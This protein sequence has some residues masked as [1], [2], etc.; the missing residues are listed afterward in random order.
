MELGGLLPLRRAGFISRCTY[1]W[2]QH[3]VA[4][5]YKRPLRE[6]DLYALDD[7]LSAD[8][9]D[10]KMDTAWQQEIKERK[11]PHL[12]HALFVAYRWEFL[13]M[14]IY[15]FVTDTSSVISPIIVLSVIK[16]LVKTSAA[17]AEGTTLPDIG[18][19]IGLT[20]ALLF[21]QLV[22]IF[23]THKARFFYLFIFKI[24]KK[25]I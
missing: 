10:E 24:L 4:T 7:E 12:M 22:T 16:F 20:F 2:I 11:T 8:N 6:E 25:K 13:T 1:H 14:G 5:G 15:R 23:S 17:K 3:F 19:G 21:V 9:N 18:L